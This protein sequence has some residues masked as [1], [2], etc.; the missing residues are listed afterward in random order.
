MYT[1]RLAGGDIALGAEGEVTYLTG[2]PKI[3][4][5]LSA[6]LLYELGGD[7]FHPWLG[8]NLESF[9]GSAGDDL[10]LATIRARVRDLLE[11]Y[12]ANQTEELKRRIAAQ[13]TNPTLAVRN[14]DPASLVK[15]FGE[16]RVE[17]E[18]DAVVVRVSFDTVAGGQGQAMV[19]LGNAL[20][21]ELGSALP[22]VVETR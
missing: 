14:A 19:A 11:T 7:R 5:D 13:P 3:A 9:V 17:A 21:P 6:W 18:R 20:R 2:P 4:H 8:S 1:V 15:H 10:T 16:I 22:E 12:H